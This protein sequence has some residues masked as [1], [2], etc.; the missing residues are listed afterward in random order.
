MLHFRI[1]K[2][3][4]YRYIS[5]KLSS[6]YDSLLRIEENRRGRVGLEGACEG[7]WGLWGLWLELVSQVTAHRVTLA[8]TLKA[9]HTR[10]ILIFYVNFC[11]VLQ[12]TGS[13]VHT[14]PVKGMPYT[15]FRYIDVDSKMLFS[16][17]IEDP[18]DVLLGL[19]GNRFINID[20]IS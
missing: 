13:P 16:A 15:L 5:Y 4:N 20:I 8:C 3:L 12:F 9:Q 17:A 11:Q 19:H 6:V 2:Q 10:Q 7:L 1:S 18:V 14:L